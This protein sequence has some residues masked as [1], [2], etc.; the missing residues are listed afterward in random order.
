MKTV[1]KFIIVIV[2]I[3]FGGWLCSKTFP[4]MKDL[5]AS[6]PLVIDETPIVIKEIRS[7][8]QLITH[9]LLDEVVA[10]TIIPTRGSG[11][12]NAFNKIIKI[13]PSADKQLV[14]IGRGKVLIGTDLAQLSDSSIRIANDTLH[15]HLPQA[16]ILDAIINPSDFETFVERGNWSN[17]EVILVKSQARRKI[18]N[19]ATRQNILPKSQLKSKEIIESFLRNMGYKNIKFF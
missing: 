8:G 13:L 11:F 6:K 14:L 2:L 12:V 4:S 17:D 5:F 7:I 9:T 1:I 16:E 15:I 19:Q 10:D 18:I 3:V